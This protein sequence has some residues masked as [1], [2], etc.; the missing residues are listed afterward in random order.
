MF[1][2]V[3]DVYIEKV[4]AVPPLDTC[5]PQDLK[6]YAKLLLHVLSNEPAS[7]GSESTSVLI[8]GS[9]EVIPRKIFYSDRYKGSDILGRIGGLHFMRC[10]LSETL[11]S[12]FSI[13]LGANMDSRWLLLHPHLTVCPVLHL[14]TDKLAEFFHCMMPPRYS[15]T[16]KHSNAGAFDHTTEDPSAT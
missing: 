3:A 7:N 4:R 8:P 15:M 1:I 12:P 10:K 16:A 9:H 6:N 2:N 14:Y 13:N 5:N 11:N